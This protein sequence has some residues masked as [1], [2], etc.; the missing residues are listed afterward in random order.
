MAR[1]GSL[2]ETGPE[3]DVGDVAVAVNPGKRIVQFDGCKQMV[4]MP[5]NGARFSR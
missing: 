5:W 1:V 2:G 4:A 3:N